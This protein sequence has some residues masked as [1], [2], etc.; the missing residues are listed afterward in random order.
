MI[1]K[2]RVKW[3]EVDL[4][5]RLKEHWVHQVL[6][7]L[8]A[9]LQGVKMWLRGHGIAGGHVSDTR[10]RQVLQQAGSVL[11][12]FD[13]SCN[14]SVVHCTLAKPDLVVQCAISQSTIVPQLFF[15][16]LL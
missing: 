13:V 15:L 6:V 9:V 16:F 10:H 14:I 5:R 4:V 7:L 3:G 2:F 1:Q 8:P 11:A 12:S